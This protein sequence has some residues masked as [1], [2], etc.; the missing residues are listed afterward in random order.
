MLNS[1][2]MTIHRAQYKA[3]VRLH[4]KYGDIIYDKRY[5]DYFHQKLG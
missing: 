2:Q 1:L 3:F 4:L 5:N